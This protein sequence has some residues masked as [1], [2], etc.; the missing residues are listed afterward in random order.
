MA[1]A[2]SNKRDSLFHGLLL[3]SAHLVRMHFVLRRQRLNRAVPAQRVQRHPL[4]EIRR[5]AAPP[6]R[7]SMPPFIHL[8]NAS[9]MVPDRV[10]HDLLAVHQLSARPR[11]S[12]L[13][14]ALV[15]QSGSRLLMDRTP[16]ERHTRRNHPADR[17][18]SWGRG[19]VLT[20]S[21]DGATRDQIDLWYQHAREGG[22]SLARHVAMCS[23]KVLKA[24]TG[25]ALSPHLSIAVR[26]R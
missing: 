7:H 12:L 18:D 10:S 16:A 23:F 20:P 25:I 11:H 15:P 1:N 4:L 8:R 19:E 26:R 21:W 3:P 13:L 9:P 2:F 6:S 14:P 24:V 5:E 22:A 17:L